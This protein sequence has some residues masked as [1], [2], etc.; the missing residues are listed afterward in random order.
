MKKAKNGSICSVC[1]IRPAQSGHHKKGVTYYKKNCKTCHRYPELG[2]KAKQTHCSVCLH[3]LHP[4]CLDIDHIQKSI[5]KD[6]SY[7]NLQVICSNCHR[8]KSL[9]CHDW[10]TFKKDRK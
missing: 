2:D 8:L 3:E 7:S 6:D 9:M 10:S 1:E 5:P 4:V